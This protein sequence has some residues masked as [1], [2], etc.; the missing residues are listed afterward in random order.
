MPATLQVHGEQWFTPTLGSIEIKHIT[1]ACRLRIW[2]S[3]S[4][5]KLPHALERV[6][7]VPGWHPK[8]PACPALSE[9][10]GEARGVA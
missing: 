4:A 10:L 2:F 5:N 9:P 8:R 1:L 7:R 6:P 3:A